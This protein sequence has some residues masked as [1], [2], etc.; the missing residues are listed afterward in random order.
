MAAGQE[1]DQHALEHLVLASDD[2]PDLEQR[3]LQS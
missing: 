3:L 2:P 1:A